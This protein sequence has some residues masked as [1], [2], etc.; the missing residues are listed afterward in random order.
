MIVSAE[1]IYRQPLAVTTSE[2]PNEHPRLYGSNDDWFSQRVEPFFEAPCEDASEH[3]VGWFGGSGVAGC[4][5][6]FWVLN[7]GIQIM[8]RSCQGWW[9]HFQLWSS[10]KL[11]SIWWRATPFI[12]RWLES[13][14]FAATTLGLC[15]EEFGVARVIYLRVQWNRGGA[16]GQVP[17]QWWIYIASTAPLG[18]AE[19]VVEEQ[20]ARC[21]LIWQLRSRWITSAL[22]TIFWWVEVTYWVWR[23]RLECR[24]PSKNKL[25]LFMS[26]F[27]T[28]HWESVEWE[29]LD[30]SS[31]HRCHVVACKLLVWRSINCQGSGGNDQ[32]YFVVASTHVYIRWCLCGRR[33]YVLLS[34]RLPDSLE[35]LRCSVHPLALRPMLLMQIPWPVWLSTILQACP[36]MHTLCQ[37][38]DSHKKRGWGDFSTLQ[39]AVASGIIGRP[40]DSALSPCGRTWIFRSFVW[41]WRLIRR[42]LEDKSRAP[43]VEPHPTLWLLAALLPPSRWEAPMQRIFSKGGYASMRLPLLV[44]DDTFPC[45]GSDT[46]E[47][48]VKAQAVVGG[49]YS[50]FVLGLC[51]PDRIP[52]RIPKWIS[53][54]LLGLHGVFAWSQ[55]MD[56]A[57]LL[58]QWDSGIFAGMN[59]STTTL[60]DII[61]WSSTKLLMVTP[62][63]FRSSIGPPGNSL[64]ST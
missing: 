34:C 28:G 58:L 59:T 49:Q 43:F 10:K 42:S 44:P 26:N 32:W 27:N 40:V 18:T 14:A 6:S 23:M 1:L 20:L 38:G 51:R 9:R 31:L 29:Q 7:Q 13:D 61:Q 4:E 41:L 12:H 17:G 16:L 50:V 15:R 62:S 57:P 60:L 54:H 63:T 3:N 24:P 56:M 25:G 55:N 19:S 46:S 11:S 37:F 21:C 48:C 52:T 39:A 45:F 64:G 5:G 47:R 53:E 8:L 30:T 33:G 36:L 22:G 35:S 2:P